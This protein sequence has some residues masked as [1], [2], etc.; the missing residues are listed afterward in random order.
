[1]GRLIARGVG[2]VVRTLG[3]TVVAVIPGVRVGDGVHIARSNGARLSAE[4]AAVERARVRLA[5]FGSVRGIAVGD[6]V[7]SD[8]AVLALPTGIALLGRAVDGTGQAIDGRAPVV[9]APRRAGGAFA[10]APHRRRAI[11]AP[12]WTGIRAV[13]GLLAFGHGAR[14]GIFGAPGAGKSSLL[15]ALVAGARC[16]AVVLSLIGERGREAQRWLERLDARTTLVCATS[17]RSA[18]ERI[19]A[20]D[21][22]M[23]QSCALAARGLRVLCVVDSLARYVAALRERRAA[24]GEPAGRGGYPPAV[25][26]DLARFLERAGNGERGSVTLVA[27]VLSDGADE[28]EPLSDAARSL[29]DGHV[30]LSSTLAG[31]GRFPAIDVLASASRT[32]AGVVDAR[33]AGDAA[34][35]RAAL[36]YLTE[37]RDARELGLG[38]A[39]EAAGAAIV[40][41]EPAIEAF[42]RSMEPSSPRRTCDALRAVV[43]AFGDPALSERFPAAARETPAEPVQ[44]M[45]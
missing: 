41:A 12:F 1:L 27:T 43:Q 30:V 11:D 14:V 2:H 22:A 7:E 37:T 39:P 33:H 16:D 18:A 38:A 42:L 21:L 9:A 35:L 40:A 13:D 10:L 4:V 32:M 6:R 28:R 31:A 26:F 29:L 44:N 24:A 25:W 15:E 17:D 3:E 19:R 45:R 20:A 8:P 5:P 23:A 36:A 34:R